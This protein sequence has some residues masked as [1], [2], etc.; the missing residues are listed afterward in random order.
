MMPM[1]RVQQVYLAIFFMFLLSLITAYP[2][3]MSID[4]YTIFKQSLNEQYTLPFSPIIALAWNYLNLFSTGP[5]IMLLLIQLLLWI[6]VF[7]FVYSWHKKHGYSNELWVFVLVPLLPSIVKASGYIWKDVLFAFSYLLATAL[8]S[9]FTL[10]KK[11]SNLLINITIFILLFFGTACKF[12]AVYI[13]PILIFWYLLSCF[14][15]SKIS[16]LFLTIMLAFTVN[17]GISKLNNFL[18]ND[19][20]ENTRTGWQEIKFFDL[21]YISLKKDKRLLPRYVQADKRFN[22]D[23]FRQK[24]V[25]STIFQVMVSKKSPIT[26]T[27][28][29]KQQQEIIEAWNHAVITYPFTYLQGRLYR[30]SRLLTRFVN[31]QPSMLYYPNFVSKEMDGY[32]NKSLTNNFLSKLQDVYIQLFFGVSMFA[33]CLPFSVYYLYIGLK[34][35]LKLGSDYGL[36]TAVMNSASVVMVIVMTFIAVNVDFR[37]LF[38]CHVMFHF[39]HPFAW[40][41]IRLY[42]FQERTQQKGFIS[43][44]KYLQ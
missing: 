37:Y 22:F 3:G 26:F 11:K 25:S 39:S 35:Y 41:A 16:A 44:T 4:S 27:V 33:L 12:Q 32:Y 38:V 20:T 34:S 31:R 17:S 18:A 1:N 30:I 6:A 5:F 7:V 15:V 28:D 29:P 9:Y 40:R 42:H 23:Q 10:H 19:Y 8:I 21:V 24:F 43:H 36:I 13:F 2:G 14:N